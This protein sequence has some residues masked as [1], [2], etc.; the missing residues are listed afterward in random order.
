MFPIYIGKCLPRKAVHSWT[1][2]VSL[3]TRRLKRRCWSVWDNTKDFYAA[4][5]D[6]LGKRWDKCINVGGG[7]VEKSFFSQVR[8]S[9]RLRFISISDLFTDSPS[10]IYVQ[11]RFVQQSNKIGL[12]SKIFIPKLPQYRIWDS[13]GS[14]VCWILPPGKSDVS[15][16]YIASKSRCKKNKPCN[17]L[18]EASS[19][20]LISYLANSPN[21]KMEAIC[22]SKTSS[23]LRTTWHYSSV[24]P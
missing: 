15:E 3:M 8:I 5:F 23:S 6:A 14:I 21:L 22:S 19:K 4:G 7:Y 9:N 18:S 2:N 13:S 12:T 20:L 1:A 11:I 17:K 10:C 16:E 24:F